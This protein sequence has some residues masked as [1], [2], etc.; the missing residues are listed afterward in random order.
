[1]D[2]TQSHPQKL[3]RLKGGLATRIEKYSRTHGPMS[4][5]CRNLQN[6]TKYF[7]RQTGSEAAPPVWLSRLFERFDQFRH[8]LE[9]VADNPI[10]GNFEYGSMRILIDG[11]DGARPLHPHQVLDRTGDADGHVHLGA[12]GLSPTA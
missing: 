7:V 3:Q 1:M 8:H 11:Y 12:H 10:I 9:Q 4:N 6:F 5:Q 2:K